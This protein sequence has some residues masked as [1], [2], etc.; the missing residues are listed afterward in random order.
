MMHRLSILFAC[1]Y[2][3]AVAMANGT[4][5]TP[6]AEATPV[7]AE[8][9]S[10]TLSESA[11]LQPE[12]FVVTYRLKLMGLSADFTLELE[13][14][15]DSRY[16]VRAT[17]QTRGI[18]KLI[19]GGAMREEARFSSDGERLYSNSYVVEGGSKSS[20]DDSDIRFD[21]DAGTA[22]SIYEEEPATLLLEGDVYDRISADIVIIN[23]LRNG[24]E[25]RDLRIAEKNEVRDYEFTFQGKETVEVPAGKFDTIKYL[26]Q[27]IGSSR[28]TLIWYAPDA[29]YL[30]V[31]MQQLKRGDPVA[32]SVATRISR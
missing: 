13:R 20:D 32:T 31:R 2:I 29:G 1:L 15:D 11:W 25:P 3:P 6:P 19:R 21:W 27:R 24:L 18:A 23:D 4:V 17:T 9:A 26:R 30:P 8:A 5:A 12:P 16:V 14:A 22:A 7:E 10:T 28:S